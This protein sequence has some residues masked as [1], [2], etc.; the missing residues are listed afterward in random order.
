MRYLK[1]SLIFIVF[2][3]SYMPID[4]AHSEPLPKELKVHFIDVGQGDS[5]LLETPN[6]KYILIDGGRPEY[7][8]KVLAYLK[9]KKVKK[10]D[11]IIASHPD[12][13]HIGGLVEV[14]KE[15]DVKQVIDS[16]KLH[17]TRTYAR[18]LSEIRKRDILFNLAMEGDVIDLDPELAIR[19]LNTYGKGRNSN[20]SSIV[21]KVEFKDITF[22]FTGDIGKEQEKR[23]SKKYDIQADIIKI[24]HHGSKTSSSIDFLKRVDPDVALLSYKKRNHFGHP[25]D[26][27]ITNLYKLDTHIYS[28][29]VFGDI[30][31]ITNGKDYY[32]D[33][34]KSPHEGILEETG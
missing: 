34:E 4:S 11:L 22:L 6:D 25:V 21:L 14:M 10:L 9:K 20:Q 28:T 17:H 32:I 3:I 5:M 31:I 33:T 15:V 29:A 26:R 7:G 8:K 30:V 2:F 19:I 18:Y 13:D 24:A 16:G 1:Y 12:Y 27:V 23:L